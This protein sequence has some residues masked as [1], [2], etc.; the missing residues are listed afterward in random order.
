VSIELTKGAEVA[1]LRSRIRPVVECHTCAI[2]IAVEMV[3]KHWEPSS[4]EHDWRGRKFDHRCAFVD[5]GP[6]PDQDARLQ[7]IEAEYAGTE[8]AA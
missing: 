1:R 3:R 2:G 5:R 4:P 8:A 7:A 6:T